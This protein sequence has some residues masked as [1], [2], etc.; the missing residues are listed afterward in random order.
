MNRLV[1]MVKA[2]VLGAVKTR[3]ARDIGG[4]QAVSAYRTMALLLVRRLARDPRW[5]LTLALAPDAALAAGV[6]PA[7]PERV[8]QGR[9]DLG[10]RMQ[11]AF[12]RFR[13][14]GPTLI[15]G[16]DIPGISAAHIAGAFRRL[17][18]LDAVLGPAADGGY[19]LIG[20]SHIRRRL[21]PFRAVRWSSAHALADTLAS[22]KGARTGL[23]GVLADADTGA[24]WRDWARQS[25][26]VRL[27]GRS[28]EF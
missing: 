12:D 19:W 7:G 24:E 6:F 13:A 1:L 8:G 14:Q 26:R 11:R 21:T 2:P 27:I 15:I 23:L 18:G 28:A 22:L 5:Q 9:G 17:R 25:A 20:L 4:A 16:S 3:L 10:R